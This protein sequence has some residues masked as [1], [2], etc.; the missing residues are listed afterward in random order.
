[1]G[2]NYFRLS[3]K[4]DENRNIDK[5]K[6]KMSNNENKYGPG[7]AVIKTRRAEYVG[8]IH[9]WRPEENFVSIRDGAAIISI[10]FDDIEVAYTYDRISIN[11]PPE[12]E[13]VDLLERAR[14]D[15]KQGRENKWFKK[16]IPMHKWEKQNG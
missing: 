15:L 11:S 3:R 4:K 7:I 12:G 9:L 14:E 13:R 10:S 16:D 6:H 5:R 1:M 2:R 8:P